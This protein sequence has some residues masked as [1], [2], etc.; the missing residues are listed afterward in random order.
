MKCLAISQLAVHVLPMGNMICPEITS[1]LS[2]FL[3]VRV[4]M[5]VVLWTFT[6]QWIAIYTIQKDAWALLL[7]VVKQVNRTTCELGSHSEHKDEDEDDNRC[8]C[9]ST[10]NSRLGSVGHLMTVNLTFGHQNHWFQLDS[11]TNIKTFFQ[12]IP[13]IFC[14]RMG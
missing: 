6:R 8:F 12:S 7:P 13:H 3:C 10:G 2:S 4:G 11:C 14:L 1:S 5:F 9:C